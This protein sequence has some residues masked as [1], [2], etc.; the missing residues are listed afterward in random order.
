MSK[1]HSSV[2]PR[3]LLLEDDP[4]L[5]E[6]LEEHLSDLGYE[7][8]CVHDGESALTVA[9][10]S[11]FDLYVLDVK[12]PYLNG[13]DLLRTLREADRT[14]PTIFITSLNTLDDLSS[15]YDAGCDD[16]LKK[17]FS[18]KELELRIKA[19]LKRSTLSTDT[20]NVIKEGVHFDLRR[21][22]IIDHDHE[23][24]LPRKEARLLK[25]LLAHPN[26]II[27]TQTLLESAWE[28]HEEA[29]EESLRTHIKNLRKY[30]GK[31]TILNVRGQGYQLVCP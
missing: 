5:I 29:S 2:L 28:F 24:I 10:E 6:I 9:Y 22:C 1:T 15:A 18:L 21:S 7:V 4:I 27:S 31:E 12:V 19:L 8:C 17:P 14:T 25:T 16:Y 23:I 30:I 11:P 26:Q 20:P 3:I 13:F